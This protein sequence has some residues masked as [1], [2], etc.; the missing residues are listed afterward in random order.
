MGT[1]VPYGRYCTIGPFNR[2]IHSKDLIGSKG[3]TSYT[4]YFTPVVASQVYLPTL[5]Y[6]VAVIWN[7]EIELWHI[8]ASYGKLSPVI[9]IHNQL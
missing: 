4:V 6:G 8:L 1:R 7:P 5:A 9:T 3:S 2:Q